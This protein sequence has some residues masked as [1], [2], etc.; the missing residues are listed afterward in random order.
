[1]LN[2]N[3][4]DKAKSRGGQAVSGNLKVAIHYLPFD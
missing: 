3:T 1:M 4:A 2:E